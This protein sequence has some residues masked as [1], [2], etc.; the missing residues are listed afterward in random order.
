MNDAKDSTPRDART[1][2]GSYERAVDPKGRFNLPFRYRRA[3]EA[4]GDEWVVTLGVDG[5]LSVYPADI[6]D[7]VFR[8]AKLNA[9]TAK[10]QAIIR[11]VS[12]NTFDLSP[13]K[14][15]RVMVPVHML[16]DAGIAKRVLVVG[17]G[18]HLELWDK[19]VYAA[20]QQKNMQMDTD[21][22]RAFFS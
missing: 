20:H 22:L 9:G 14:Q 13:D 3:E 11:H 19:D 17:M 12:A 6:W 1:F 16:E 15:G 5:N 4:G 8:T 7:E 2:S 18:D 21:F 10:E